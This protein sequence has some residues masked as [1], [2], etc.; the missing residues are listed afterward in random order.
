MDLSEEIRLGYVGL[1]GCSG[2]EEGRGSADLSGEIRLVYVGSIWCSD[3]EE[4]RV[5]W[6]YQKRFDW[7]I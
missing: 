6:T 1:I 4:V 2:T 5:P 7:G 3:A